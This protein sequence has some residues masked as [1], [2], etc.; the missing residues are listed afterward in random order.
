MA[1]LAGTQS[2]E[3][4]DV[5][6]TG[7]S[8]ASFVFISMSARES[9]G[10][11]AEYIEWHSL[12]H[13]PEQYRLRGLRSSLRLVSTHECRAARAASVERFDTA[14]HPPS[15]PRAATSVARGLTPKV[16]SRL[17]GTRT[18]R[19]R[20]RASARGNPKREPLAHVLIFGA[21]PVF[22]DTLMLGSLGVSGRSQH[23]EDTSA[24]SATV[25]AATAGA[26][27]THSP[28]GPSQSGCTRTAPTP[29]VD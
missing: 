14:D 23:G 16:T 21:A 6:A 12:D 25:T 13:G 2:D 11:D 8:D 3:L 20:P 9:D 24:E 17:P 15:A 4:A 26:T 18:M 27:H 19:R 28:A 5:L 22:V 1:D 10:R 7:A 29:N